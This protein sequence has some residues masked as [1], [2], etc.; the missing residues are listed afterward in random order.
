MVNYRAD[1]VIRR[2][3]LVELILRRT[4]GKHEE[5]IKKRRNNMNT[6]QI[7]SIGSSII[8]ASS[9][10]FHYFPPYVVQAV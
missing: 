2:L 1:A 3:E 7:F 4:L 6:V 10:L 8:R 9:I 5:T